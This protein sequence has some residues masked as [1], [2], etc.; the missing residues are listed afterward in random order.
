MKKS[1]IFLI[2]SILST[3]TGVSNLSTDHKI[4]YTNEASPSK[5]TVPVGKSFSDSYKIT[6]SYSSDVYTLLTNNNLN[7]FLNTYERIQVNGFLSV[8]NGYNS[9][10]WYTSSNPVGYVSYITTS[11]TSTLVFQ[12]SKFFWNSNYCYL[13]LY[14]WHSS[15]KIYYQWRGY[16]KGNNW[17]SIKLNIKSITFSKGQIPTSVYYNP[18]YSYR[19]SDYFYKTTTYTSSVQ[20]IALPPNSTWSS[21]FYAI[22]IL[23]NFD[24]TFSN[25]TLYYQINTIKFRTEWLTSN[26]NDTFTYVLPIFDYA[27]RYTFVQISFWKNISNNC[28]SFQ[29]TGYFKGDTNNYVDMSINNNGVQFLR[30]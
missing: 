1:L 27:D 20:N 3:T 2:T 14:L 29:W 19:Y 13:G 21:N 30:S 23:G 5:Y 16:F 6:T 12:S 22:R 25:K 24:A 17:D 28:L 15:N 8:Q 4:N 26:K 10:P 7:D 18:N 11:N 9:S